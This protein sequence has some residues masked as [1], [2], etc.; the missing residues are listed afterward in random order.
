ML[1]MCR[2]PSAPQLDGGV[3]R[4]G[5]AAH[6]CPVFMQ[7]LTAL[8]IA[9][10]FFLSIGI[11]CPSKKLSAVCLQPYL[12]YRGIFPCFFGGLVSRLLM[13][14]SSALISVTRVSRG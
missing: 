12:I 3:G 4:I 10:I 1:I 13:T 14:V 11:P 6:S 7:L 5:A 8:I 9:A 2:R